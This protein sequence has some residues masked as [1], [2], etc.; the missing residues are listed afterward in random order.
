[1]QTQQLVAPLRTAS[2]RWQPAQAPQRSHARQMTEAPNERAAAIDVG[3]I[4]SADA[5]LFD[6]RATE[7]SE[8]KH[9]RRAGWNLNSCSC[10]V[11]GL[12]VMMSRTD[13]W[14]SLT[15]S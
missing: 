11:R 9:R 7:M 5:L 8:L 12:L 2:P 15:P 1:M 6:Q 14:Q 13:Q 3:E 10:Y 4:G